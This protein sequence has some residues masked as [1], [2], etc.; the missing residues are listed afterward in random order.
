M[1][2]HSIL[3]IFFGSSISFPSNSPYDLGKK[4]KAKFYHL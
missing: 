3:T 1:K 2:G 4:I